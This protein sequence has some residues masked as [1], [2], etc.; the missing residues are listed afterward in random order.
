MAKPTASERDDGRRRPRGARARRS[1]LTSLTGNATASAL[2][3]RCVTAG[4]SP[5]RVRVLRERGQL[6]RPE[7]LYLPFEHDAELLV[8]PTPSLGHQRDRVLRTGAARVLDE[9]R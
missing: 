9:V 1:G 8:R 4:T 2:R 7:Q 6:E 3:L 5:R